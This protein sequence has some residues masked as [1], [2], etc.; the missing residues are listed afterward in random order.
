MAIYTYKYRLGFT[1]VNSECK[2]SNKAALKML[3]NAAGTHSESV[4]YGLNN[5]EDKGVT[6]VILSW[7]V[8]IL[9]RPKYNSQLTVNTWARDPN[10][11]CI[12][13]DYEILDEAG[14]VC[15][16][17]TSKCALIDLKTEKLS[18]ITPELVKAY[19]IEKTSVFEDCT[20]NKLPEPKTIV[21]KMKYKIL[22]SDIDMNKHVHNLYYL[23]FAYET[24]PEDIYQA[25]ELNNMEIMYK[26]QIKLGDNVIC[27]YTKEDE[28]NIVT[29][30]SE[31]D[32]I[33]HTVIYLY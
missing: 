33:L 21:S 12:Y 10:K 1:D 24:L 30:K 28:K 5:R 18:P 31:D 3:E 23:D 4:G 11:I 32:S 19:K 26:K 14:E 13:R 22:R 27:L 25:G 8:K 17:A 7:K 2:M 16:L 6:W 20:L 29:I 15:V 9:K